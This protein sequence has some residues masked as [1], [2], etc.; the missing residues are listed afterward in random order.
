MPKKRTLENN[1]LFPV[2][3]PRW[4]YEKIEDIAKK[5]TTDLAN[6]VRR[7]I[8]KGLESEGVEI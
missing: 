8:R 5:E 1:V 3:L 7:L 2:R 4:M 6:V